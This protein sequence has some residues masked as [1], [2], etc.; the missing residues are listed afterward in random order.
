LLIGGFNSTVNLVPKVGENVLR[1]IRG[2][3]PAV[4]VVNHEIK[5]N[6]ES[7][8]LVK[9]GIATQEPFIIDV[10]K[11]SNSSLTSS[12]P[13]IKVNE[14]IARRDLEENKSIK[15]KEI[16]KL[17]TET[18]A[19]NDHGEFSIIVKTYA[20]TASLKINGEEQGSIADGDYSIKRVARVGQVTQFTITA[21]DVYGNSDTK[22][23]TVT[24]QAA[25]V[26]D[27]AIALKPEV[28]KRAP[29]RDAVAII[30][31]I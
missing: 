2:Q 30:I 19:Q 16:I 21:V 14:K 29:T 18:T 24:R 15:S 13:E 25:P 8:M 20:D 5:F 27:T 28:I 3:D 17:H 10:F 9:V 22:I 31:A 23:I 1:K 7:G 4:P 11:N 26:T 12:Q 6:F